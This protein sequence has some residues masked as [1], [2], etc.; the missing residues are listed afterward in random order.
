[1]KNL[2]ML[3][4]ALAMIPVVSRRSH[5]DNDLVEFLHGF[6]LSRSQARPIVRL[7]RTITS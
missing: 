4:V 2:P 1:M 5:T 7:Y 3:K 6:G